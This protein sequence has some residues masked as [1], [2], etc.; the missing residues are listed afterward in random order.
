[1]LTVF[2]KASFN[3]VTYTETQHNSSQGD[4]EM[5]DREQ[6]SNCS[7]EMVDTWKLFS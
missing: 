7:R 4:S 1:M 3:H 5:C 6:P 2:S